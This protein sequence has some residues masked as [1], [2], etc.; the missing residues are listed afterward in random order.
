MNSVVLSCHEELRD[1]VIDNVVNANY[2]QA[3]IIMDLNRDL[4]HS[5]RFR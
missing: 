3:Y 1:Q 4:S 5:P 2:H